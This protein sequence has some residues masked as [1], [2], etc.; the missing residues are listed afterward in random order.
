MTKKY[1]V[2]F[3]SG[4]ENYFRVHIGDNVAK[5]PYNYDDI[6]LSKQDRMFLVKWLKRKKGI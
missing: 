3:D 6:Y 2:T 1:K 5:F 4:D